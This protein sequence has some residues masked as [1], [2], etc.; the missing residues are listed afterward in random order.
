METK[1]IVYI[2]SNET[3][4][5]IYKIGRTK[6]GG[7]KNRIRTL[8]TANPKPFRPVIAVEV[9]DMKKTETALHT[10]YSRNNEGG[11]FYKFEPELIIPLLG[12][13]GKDIT[14]TFDR[15]VD[16]ELTVEQRVA[17]TTEAK[18]EESKYKK[19]NGIAF[20]LR[21]IDVEMIVRDGKFVVLKNSCAKLDSAEHLQYGTYKRILDRRNELIAQDMFILEEG[22]YRLSEDIVFDNPSFAAAVILG[23]SVSRDVWLN[24]DNKSFNEVL[25]SV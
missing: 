20:H 3:L 18:A 5:G 21:N 14:N 2:L 10:L 13:M 7:L 15:V 23:R 19:L 16:E 22:I 4:P 1:G 6:I 11:E 9:E 8:N 12:L 25:G 17:E 24:A